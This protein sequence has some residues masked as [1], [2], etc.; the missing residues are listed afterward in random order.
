M[1]YIERLEFFIFMVSDV[2]ASMW[3]IDKRTEDLLTGSHMNVKPLSGSETVNVNFLS[4]SLLP[5]S[6]WN[7]F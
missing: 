1:K 6:N 3:E 5:A 2:S 4:Y 7:S